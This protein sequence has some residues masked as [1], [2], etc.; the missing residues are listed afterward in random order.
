MEDFWQI[1]FHMF[2][3][4]AFPHLNLTGNWTFLAIYHNL[5]L[6]GASLFSFAVKKKNVVLI[7]NNRFKKKM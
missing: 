6:L 1:V 7:K 2:T 4:K 5:T 3:I